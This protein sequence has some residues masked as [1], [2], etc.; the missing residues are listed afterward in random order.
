MDRKS[1]FAQILKNIFYSFLPIPI[2]FDE[3]RIVRVTSLDNYSKQEVIREDTDKFKIFTSI[4]IGIL[5]LSPLE[6]KLTA[7]I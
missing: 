1:N 7:F 4:H 2:E 3:S 5:S 6:I